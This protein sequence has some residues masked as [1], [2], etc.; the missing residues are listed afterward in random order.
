MYYSVYIGVGFATTYDSFDALERRLGYDK[1]PKKV[2]IF[3]RYPHVDEEDVLRDL[4][5]EFSLDTLFLVTN[6]EHKERQV[7]F[8]H[9]L[10]LQTSSLDVV[11]SKSLEKWLS[12]VA[13]EVP[14][15]FKQLRAIVSDSSEIGLVLCYNGTLY[16]NDS[17][18]TKCSGS[19]TREESHAGVVGHRPM[20]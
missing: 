19:R 20:G 18:A 1:T 16:K 10:L 5:R 14:N 3:R 6:P 7:V 17:T 13:S 4:C 9:R 15:N 11:S 12:A 2:G 8:F